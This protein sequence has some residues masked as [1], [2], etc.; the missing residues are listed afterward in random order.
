MAQDRTANQNVNRI[1][2]G[3]ERTQGLLEISKGERPA[4]ELKPAQY[5]H[6]IREDKYLEDWV[7]IEAGTIVSVD[8]SGFLVPCNGWQPQQI[9]YDANDV[10]LTVDIDDAGHD[11]YVTVAG[12]SSDTVGANRPVGVA[13]YDYYANLNAGF[14]STGATKYLNYQIQDKVAILC[15]YLIEVPVLS[16]SDA[17]GAIAA[18]DLVQ[19]DT[20][21]KF[22]QWV[23][24]ASDVSQ[25][26]GR[27][28]QRTSTAV[29][30]HLD[31][32]QTVPGLGLSGSATS[33]VPSHLYDYDND[34]PYT[35]K[36]LIQL[37]VA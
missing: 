5:L 6:V 17:S 32:V 19:S 18:G 23:D 30:D 26:V 29:V 3:Y 28:I 1:P 4:L 8:P 12:T 27:C 20:D 25:I 22:I 13:P 34:T 10:G 9:T 31:K 35:E 7:V 33:G 16:T 36:M 2:H 21:G 11:T 24:G 14:G 15:D 37:M